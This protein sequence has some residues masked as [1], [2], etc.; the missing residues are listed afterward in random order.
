M[1]RRHVRRRPALPAREQGGDAVGAVRCGELDA[2]RGGRSALVG[3]HGDAVG[4]PGAGR[5]VPAG[6][7][8]AGFPRGH[9]PQTVRGGAHRDPARDPVQQAALRVGGLHHV[10]RLGPRVQGAVHVGD[11]AG[12]QQRQQR[13]ETEV[14]GDAGRVAQ[15]E[16]GRG[17]VVEALGAARDHRAAVGLDDLD[18]HGVLPGD[19]DRLRVAGGAVPGAVRAERLDTGAGAAQALAVQVLVVGHRV[20]DGPGD[21]AGVAEVGDAR[22]AG[23]R[24][25]DDV[26]LRAGQADLLVDAGVF[27][28]AVRVAR[29][30]RLPGGGPLAAHQPAVAAR[31][32]GAVGGEQG[33]GVLAE[34]RGDVLAPELGGEAREEDVGGEPD[35]E[36]G[37]GSPPSGGEAGADELRGRVPGLGEP[38]V[39]AVDVRPHPGRR[40]RVPFLQGGEA[41]A[42]GVREPGAAGETVPGQG[43]G[44]EEG[45]GGALGAVPLDLQLPGTVAGGHPALGAGEFVRGVRAQVRDSP[46]VA[47]GLGAHPCASTFL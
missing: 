35:A 47:V 37:P 46:G 1:D 22:D 20:G 40:L 31:R 26:E 30:D 19:V 38:L 34:V 25:A 27:D 36:R 15:A 29:D 39:H 5:G 13:A 42:C 8:V 44:S 23:H 11:P 10:D 16:G 14:G 32:A 7:L 21:R 28:E 4:E 12:P 33:H 2:Q 3:H 24:E 41:A 18:L 6:P 43:C 9:R 45:R 17:A